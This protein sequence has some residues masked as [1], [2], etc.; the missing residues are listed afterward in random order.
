LP[1][2]FLTPMNWTTR[3]RAGFALALLSATAA[4]P[5]AELL[6]AH[7][8]DKPPFVFGS[9]QRGLE[10]DIMREALAY[11]GHTMR[12]VHVPNKRLQVAIGTGGVDGAATVRQ[13]EDG[14][15]Y[16]DDFISFE[17]VAITRRS[18]AIRLDSVDDLKGHTL[19]AWQ[20]AWRDLGPKFEAAFNPNVKAPYRDAYSEL[21]S[22]RNQNLMFW[23]G[24]AQVIIVDRTIFLWYR[25][26]LATQVDT[27]AE[28]VFHTIFPRRTHFQAAFKERRIRDDFNEGLRHLRETGRYRQLYDAYV[29]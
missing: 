2:S 21:P 9:E 12:V 18:D 26:E 22:Q 24:R 25:K 19:V 15:H 23:L 6:I 13:A 20:N 11:R 14:S 10:V 27:S 16:S 29:K 4:V 1:L 8:L 17:N 7:G 28:V 5:A 3:L